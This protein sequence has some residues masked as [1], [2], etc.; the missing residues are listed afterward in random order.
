M[1]TYVWTDASSKCQL[2]QAAYVWE[3]LS[4]EKDIAS[5]VFYPCGMNVPHLNHQ[6]Q[7]ICGWDSIQMLMN[8]KQHFCGWTKMDPK[9]PKSNAA[10]KR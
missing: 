4:K 7:G 2:L 1:Q 3:V 6:P 9:H 8:L 5:F 10:N